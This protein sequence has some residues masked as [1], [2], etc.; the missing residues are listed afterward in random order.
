MVYRKCRTLGGSGGTGSLMWNNLRIST[1][2]ITANAVRTVTT[3]KYTSEEDERDKE[4]VKV[5]KKHSNALLNRYIMCY[6][7]GSLVL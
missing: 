2:V 7:D 3:N 1:E 4:L 5:V 6:S